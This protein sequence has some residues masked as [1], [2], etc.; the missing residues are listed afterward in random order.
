MRA[1]GLS[2]RAIAAE[3]GVNEFTPFT[4]LHAYV[5]DCGR[6]YTVN[7]PRCAQCARE[8]A[9]RRTRDVAR[10]MWTADSV[11]EAINDWARLEGHAPRYD[12]WMSGRHATGRWRR[13]YPRWPSAGTV[14]RLY[15]GWAAALR[16]AGY[17][18]AWRSFTD[19]EVI[20]ALRAS[21]ATLGRAPLRSEWEG[22]SPE[23]PGVGAVSRHFGTWNDGLRAAGLEVP[24]DRSAWTPDRV[25]QALRR[26]ARR[27]GRAPTISEWRRQTRS[28]PSAQIAAALF[29]T[30]N[31]A[32]RA[33][34]LDVNRDP[35]KWRRETVL[36]GLQRLERELRRRPI[37]QDVRDAPAGYPSGAVVRRT[38]GSWA[39]AARELGWTP[40]EHRRRRGA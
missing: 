17:A 11:I 21:A 29:G 18:P 31:D 34:G 35:G 32:L 13:E 19:E 27:R 22:R 9:A 39:A 1:A 33:A 36:E 40:V 4:Y 2:V 6:N 12:E 38:F 8:S 24:H 28:R 16:G 7:G 37:W 10:P 5:C 25:I 14:Q 26:E 3:L 20:D 15:G 23:A 30:W